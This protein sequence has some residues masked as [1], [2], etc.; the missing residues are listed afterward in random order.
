MRLA[1]FQN[2]FCS[3][4]GNGGDSTLTQ[5]E[6]ISCLC[7]HYVCSVG[8]FKLCFCFSELLLVWE[9]LTLQPFF[10]FVVVIFSGLVLRKKFKRSN[11][12]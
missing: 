1:L 5:S 9:T 8:E 3:G 2:F 11:E 12:K 10:V 4:M 6:V 7:A